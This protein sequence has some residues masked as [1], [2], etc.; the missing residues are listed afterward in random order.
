MSVDFRKCIHLEQ[1]KYCHAP[2][3]YCG[4]KPKCDAFREAN[5]KAA[6]QQEQVTPANNVPDKCPMCGSD[7]YH[8]Y[9]DNNYGGIRIVYMCNSEWWTDCIKYPGGKLTESTDCLRNQLTQRTAERDWAYVSVGAHIIECDITVT[10]GKNA[11]P[12]HLVY[13]T[14]DFL[15]ELL[16]VAYTDD[17]YRNLCFAIAEDMFTEATK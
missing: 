10:T 3:G 1:G 16:P 2:A 12:D 11:L 13:V 4:E 6:K 8:N 9:G 5:R 7:I 15:E 17:D 14:A